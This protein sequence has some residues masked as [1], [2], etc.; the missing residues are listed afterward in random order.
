M[1]TLSG[2]EPLTEEDFNTLSSIFA[3][4]TGIQLGDTKRSM[5]QSRILK[6]LRHLGF[7]EFNEYCD[8]IT[9]P[10]NEE[11]RKILVDLLTTNQT[12]FFR[13]KRH[14][15]VLADILKAW[16]SGLGELNLWSAASSSG[17]E[18][19]TMATVCAE[20]IPDGQPW[21][22]FGSD[23]NS[24]VVAKARLAEYSL[25]EAQNIPEKIL[26]KYFMKGS[27]PKD[28]FIAVRPALRPAVEFKQMNLTGD[29]RSAGPFDIAFLRN[30]L[31]Y[32]QGKNRDNIVSNVVSR[33]KPGGY[34]FLGHSETLTGPAKPLFQQISSAVYRRYE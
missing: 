5:V 15:E 1:I 12:Y 20:N 23:I 27:G 21:H 19:W 34:L 18:A 3:K 14:F 28:G 6:R 2:T 17:Q 7:K 13:E 22:I 16:P 24:E 29:M 4:R 33:I 30:V 25:N 31:I 26:K 10:E 8:H 9:K 11:E 32:F